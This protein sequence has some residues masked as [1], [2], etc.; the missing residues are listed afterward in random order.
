MHLLA[1]AAK[2]LA[3]VQKQNLAT[4]VILRRSGSETEETLSARVKTVVYD[5]EVGEG[6]VER[7]ESRA[8]TFDVADLG[9]RPR[10]GDEIVED[11]ALGRS[12]YRVMSPPGLP[13]THFSDAYRT[14]VV[15]HSKL[16]GTQTL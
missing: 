14:G 16:V 7:W 4:A 10:E 8:F 2:Y 12:T 11:H 3:D 5:V 6:R 1:T 9:S 13:P 15:V